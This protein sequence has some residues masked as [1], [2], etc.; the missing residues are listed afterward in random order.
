M[1]SEHYDQSE[2]GERMTDNM[3]LEELK[4]VTIDYYVNLQRIKKADTGNNPEL[5]YQLKVVKIN[6]PL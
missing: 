3:A 4:Q 1:V 2:G 6:W 5:A